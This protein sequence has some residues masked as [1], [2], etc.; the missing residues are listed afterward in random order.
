MCVANFG[1]PILWKGFNTQHD[2]WTIE[3]I[4]LV[5]IFRYWSCYKNLNLA[6][7]YNMSQTVYCSI[8]H[9]CMIQRSCM[10]FI[11]FLSENLIRDVNVHSE[12]KVRL[13]AAKKTENIM[14][15]KSV[16]IDFG[17]AVN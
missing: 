4:I 7:L 1:L 3:V 14:V 11:Q 6:H 5:S 13:F 9:F 12:V 16:I 10:M 15:K 17:P 2:G 8:E